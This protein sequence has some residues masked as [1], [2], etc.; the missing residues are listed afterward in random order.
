MEEVKA[1]T[2]LPERNTTLYA[3]W[4]RG[5]AD[6]FGSNDY[7][8]VIDK[9][10]ENIYL[11]RGDVF[12]QG[13]MLNDTDF[14]F[15]NSGNAILR[16]KLLEDGRF[17]YYKTDRRKS[18]TLFVTGK[19]LVETDKIFFDEY[20]GITY[21]VEDEDGNTT[22]SVGEYIKDESGYYVATFTEGDGEY[23][24][25]TLTLFVGMYK[26]SSAFQ[27]RNEEEYGMGQLV[28]GTVYEG[29]LTYYTAAYQ[30]K[31]TGFGTALRNEVFNTSSFLYT[32]EGDT[33]TLRDDYGQVKD[34]VRII[35][36]NGQK[37]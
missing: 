32:L 2:F 17:A 28:C 7:I 4:N 15:I 16:G 14:L 37:A 29:V 12:F 3:V 24:G 22:Q 25:K 35:E 21:S 33:I 34:V 30:L 31:L 1:D 19:G 18:S 9:A 13:K 6:M 20:N 27:V 11:S 23:V 8:Y 36:I 5:Y 26:D 10:S